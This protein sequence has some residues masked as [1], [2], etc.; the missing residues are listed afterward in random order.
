MLSMGAVVG[1]QR[2]QTLQMPSR[3]HW[4]ASLIV[5][6]ICTWSFPFCM[7][8][9]K[10]IVWSSSWI[11]WIECWAK[12]WSLSRNLIG[13]FS[14]CFFKPM[15]VKNLNFFHILQKIQFDKVDLCLLPREAILL[16]QI[17][18]TS[19]SSSSNSNNINNSSNYSLLSPQSSISQSMPTIVQGNSSSNFM[20]GGNDLPSSSIRQCWAWASKSFFNDDL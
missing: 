9:N 5:A 10:L 19:S 20:H 7:V 13:E 3:V 8:S 11:G 1:R 14:R 18:S 12:K 2:R 17:C 16:V 4:W 15:K 6:P